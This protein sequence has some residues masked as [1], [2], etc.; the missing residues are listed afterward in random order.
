MRESIGSENRFLTL[1]AGGGLFAIP[2]C[3]IKG[4]VIA[5]QE[6]PFAALPHMPDHVKGVVTVGDQLVTVITLPGEKKDVQLLGKHI[7]MLVH[8]ER[9]IGVVANSV[10]L[11]TIP[12]E[13]I[14]VD[15]IMGTKTCK[16]GNKMFSIVDINDL[17]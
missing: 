16:N 10:A 2:I 7:V 3:D 11:A 4:I 6:M 1:E 9:A 5:H 14:S 15:Q 17:F 12:E 8:P 13:D